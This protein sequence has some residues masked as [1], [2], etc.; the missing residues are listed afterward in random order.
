MGE[1]Y[2]LLKGDVC[3]SHCQGEVVLKG[4]CP[5][6]NDLVT[7]RQVGCYTDNSKITDKTVSLR[8]EGCLS[9]C[10]YSLTRKKMYPS[11]TISGLVDLPEGIDKYYQQALRS[12]SADNPDGAVTAF[13][14][15]IHALGINYCITTRNDKIGIYKIVEG[16]HSKG[17]IVEKL[18]DALLGVK[19]IGNDGAHINDNEPDLGQAMVIK[20]LIDAVLQSTV[21]V[22]AALE[23][24]REKHSAPAQKA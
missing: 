3:K 6:C 15:I 7:F 22:D 18:K 10:S 24:V 9:F 2:Q 14:K 11:P 13:R 16:L 4:R 12:L 20:G 21:L 5:F 8:C 23:A 1:G 17:H 19:D